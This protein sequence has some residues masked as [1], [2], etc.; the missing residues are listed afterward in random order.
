V[1]AGAER[2]IHAVAV[3]DDPDRDVAV[4]RLGTELDVTR[5]VPERVVDEVAQRPFEA[6]RVG[7][8][9]GTFLARHGDPAIFLLRPRGE[10]DCQCPEQRTDVDVGPSRLGSTLLRRRDDKQ[11][12]GELR[13]AVDL[14]FSRV[15]G[16]QQLV[17]RSWV[18]EREVELRLE[19][20]ERRP[21]LVAGLGDEPAFAL[22]AGTCGTGRFIDA[23]GTV[24]AVMKP[25]NAPSRSARTSAPRPPRVA[26]AP[27]RRRGRA[28]PGPS[29]PRCLG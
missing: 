29:P 24:V 21:Q 3:V 19:Q 18:R 8:G 4:A 9:D 28:R 13:E 2:V 16:G 6:P 1:R 22:K 11:V 20:G 25:R 12:L 14:P 10:A 27:G 23:N 5:P 15:Q 17:G 26:R 7:P